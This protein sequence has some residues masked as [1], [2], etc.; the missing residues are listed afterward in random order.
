MALQ[1]EHDTDT[2][3]EMLAG[4]RGNCADYKR[5]HDFGRAR[6]PF[7]WMS[8]DDSEEANE[9]LESQLQDY[10]RSGE[11]VRFEAWEAEDGRWQMAFTAEV[12]VLYVEIDTRL[13]KVR[14]LLQLIPA[15]QAGERTRQPRSRGKA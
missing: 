3:K 13:P 11:P 9:L 2:K 10:Q 15:F 4:N 5:S 8:S 7:T 12:R 6:E 1:F 14:A